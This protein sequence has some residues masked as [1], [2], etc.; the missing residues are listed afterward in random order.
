MK[1]IRAEALYAAKATFIF[2]WGWPWPKFSTVL[3][4][5]SSSF[6]RLRMNSAGVMSF[7][8]ECVLSWLYSLRQLSSLSCASSSERN[9][10][11]FRHSSRRLPLNDSINGLSVG[12]PGR[13]KSIVTPCSCKHPGKADHSHLEIFL[14]TDY[15]PGGDRHAQSPRL[16]WINQI[17]GK[18]PP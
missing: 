3:N 1:N 17:S 13:E 15:V 5:R 18:S 6:R 4:Q 7:N 11:M 10:W 9:Q 2:W 8:D 12:F 16:C 14:H